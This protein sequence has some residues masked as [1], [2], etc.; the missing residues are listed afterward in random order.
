[1]NKSEIVWV[2]GSSAVGKDTFIQHIINDR[3]LNLFLQMGWADKKLLE[4]K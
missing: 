1:M 2:F 3:P 4:C